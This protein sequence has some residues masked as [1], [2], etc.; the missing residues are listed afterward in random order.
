MSDWRK[1]EAE[2]VEYFRQ[3]G[4]CPKHRVGDEPFSG[5]LIV[6]HGNKP[7]NLSDLARELTATIGEP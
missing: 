6:S 4:Y 2:I 1:V 7:I 3:R 5:D